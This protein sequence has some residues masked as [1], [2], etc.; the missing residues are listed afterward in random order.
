VTEPNPACGGQTDRYLKNRAYPTPKTLSPI[1][2]RLKVR[3][4][5][6]APLSGPL[7]AQRRLSIG[8][9]LFHAETHAATSRIDVKATFAWPT[10]G[11]PSL[12][13]HPCLPQAF[14]ISLTA[15]LD[16]R[17][18]AR[19]HGG[20]DAGHSEGR[21]EGKPLLDGGMRLVEATQL[22]KGGGERKNRVR[23]ISVGFERASRPIDRILVAAELKLCDA[24]EIHPGGRISIA[25]TEA[26]RLF[27]VSLRLLLTTDNSLGKSKTGMRGGEIA[28][29]LQRM[30]AL[31]NGLSGPW[32]G[33]AS[34]PHTDVRPGR[35][36]EHLMRRR[37]A[38]HF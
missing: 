26:Q 19:R 37:E 21:V 11:S 2:C 27:D 22:R 15:S 36:S 24:S 23:V 34:N 16:H 20:A 8:V 28:I 12:L 5:P 35:L 25:R 30:L 33:F 14:E 29:Q 10:A 9:Q 7:F 18:V 4:D 6:F 1:E 13:G 38:L 17:I 31:G 32:Q 3:F